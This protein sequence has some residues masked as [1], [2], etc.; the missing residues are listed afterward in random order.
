MIDKSYKTWLTDLKGKIRSAQI[1]AAVSV[2]TELIALYWDMGKMITEKQTAWGTGFLEQLSKDLKTEFPGMQGFSRRNLSNT[3]NFYQFYIASIVQQPVGLIW[4]QPV[5][6]LPVLENDVKNQQ[7]VDQ[8]QTNSEIVKQPD[9][10]I[11]QHAVAQIP[12]GHNILIFSK[13]KD[14]YEA[15]FYVHQTIENNWS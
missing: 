10:S 6:K 14:V 3:V 13:S 9:G 15:N 12:W 11:V 7:P 2:N 1:K 8:L 5:A 4:Q